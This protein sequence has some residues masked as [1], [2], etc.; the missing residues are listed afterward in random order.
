MSCSVLYEKVRDS[1]PMS[2]SVLYEKVR[3]SDSESACFF[4]L[5]RSAGD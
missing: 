4:M 5:R 2:C 3:E 1:V